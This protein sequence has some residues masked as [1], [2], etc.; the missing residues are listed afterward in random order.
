M[1]LPNMVIRADSP[2]DAWILLNSMVESDDSANT[3][4]YFKREFEQF[5]MIVAKTAREYVDRA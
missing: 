2:S 3:R 5:T 4:D 1:A